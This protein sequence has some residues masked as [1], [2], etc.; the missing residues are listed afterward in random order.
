MTSKYDTTKLFES[1]DKHIYA[2]PKRKV[3][4]FLN[5]NKIVNNTLLTQSEHI[6]YHNR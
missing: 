4:R 2:T 5:T 3:H 6:N 1:T